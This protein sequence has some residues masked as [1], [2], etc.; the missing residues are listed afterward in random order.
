MTKTAAIIQARMGST[1]LPGK[2]LLDVAG[3]PML[4]KS[5]QRAME[6]ETVDQVVVAT[7]VLSRDDVVA[8][9]CAERG[10]ACHRGSE[11]DVLDRYYQAA[12]EFGVDNIIRL[13]SDCPLIDPE[14]IDLVVGMFLQKRPDLDYACS[15]LP[16]RTFP[17]G[18]DVEVFT[19][20]ALEKAWSEDSNPLFREHVTMYFLKNPDLFALG[21][22][23]WDT[24]LSHLR[25]TVDQPEDLELIRQIYARFT[26]NTFSWRQ[27]LDLFKEH[28]ELAEINRHVEQFTI[29]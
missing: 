27:V 28:P 23:S 15:F 20:Q 26:T 14:V 24:N 29:K 16:E 11:D 8:A 25:W 21:G 17:R 18:M 3:E 7:T 5:V 1:R 10:W 9:Y 22:V 2:I 6:A 13:T 4:A 12:R 19:F